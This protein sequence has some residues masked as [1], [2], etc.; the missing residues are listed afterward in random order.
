MQNLID[1]SLKQ[2]Y[3]KVKELRSRLEDM[4]SSPQPSS[5]LTH[6]YNFK[7]LNLHN[8]NSKIYILFLF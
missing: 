5:I 3:A 8:Q 7:A 1:F 6:A 4:T 2:K